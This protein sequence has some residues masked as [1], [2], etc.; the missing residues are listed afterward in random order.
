MIDNANIVLISYPPGGFGHF[1]FHALTEFADNT[2]KPI[3]RPF[4]FSK[5]GNSHS[6]NKYTK[7]YFRDPTNYQT[8]LPDTDKKILVLC[9]NGMNNDSYVKI[10]ET[11]PAASILRLVITEAVRPVIYQTCIAKAKQSNIIKEVQSHV[12][13]NWSD[14]TEDYAVRENFTLLYHNWSYKWT[15]CIAP[16]ITNVRIESLI[17]NPSQTITQ[18]IEK[19]GGQVTNIAGLEKL[20]Q[21]WDNA[22]SLYFSAYINWK[23][24]NLALDCNELIDLSNITDLHEQGYLN[25]CIER[26]YNVTIPVYDCRNWFKNT[27]DIKK[28]LHV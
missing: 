25:Y 19:L 10:R 15:E 22:N 12:S 27:N 28:Y 11:F 3:D 17:T 16:D 2:Y 23:K 6:S 13:S 14:I 4:K 7:I 24:I 26:K 8:V 20:C 9:D 1:L 18:V 5:D 21:Q